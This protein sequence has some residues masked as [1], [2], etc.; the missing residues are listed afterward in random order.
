MIKE[1]LQILSL[2]LTCLLTLYVFLSWR[3]YG[4]IKACVVCTG[5]FTVAFYLDVI[6]F[7]I[8]RGALQE[9]VGYMTELLSMFMSKSIMISC[10]IP[11]KIMLERGELND[12]KSVFTYIDGLTVGISLFFIG[13]AVGCILFEDDKVLSNLIKLII[14]L[15]ILISYYFSAYSYERKQAE[16]VKESEAVQAKHE[17]SVY[18][19]NVENN[20]Q[21]TRE[22]WHDLKNHINLMSVLLR[23]E[24]YNELSDY[25]RIFGEDIDS[26]TLP[27]KSGNVIVDALLADKLSKAKRGGI[28]V[29]LS[30]CDLTGL[31][32]KA[33]E[34]CGLLG[35]LLDNAIE[36]AS[37][38]TV[39][40]EKRISVECRDRNDC[41]YISVK[42]SQS[43][44][45]SFITNNDE[46]IVMPKT[47]KTDMRNKV[48]HGLGLRSVERIVH[49][50]G[51]ELAMNSVETEFTVVVRLP[52]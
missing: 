50:C 37:N 49:G 29:E 8:V 48:G 40:E 7:L 20:Y 18:L 36:A 31:N 33:D 28:R 4:R 43:L 3:R 32:L 1:I 45:H 30:L 26:L 38:A 5:F 14:W 51:G 41:Y 6:F 25:L 11:I 46:E 47:I 34:I 10:A 15:G 21:R 39:V 42:N 44:K 27:M 16:K 52:R 9:D 24:K 23:E 22:L 12:A 17:T 2:F 35:N 13:L 19:E